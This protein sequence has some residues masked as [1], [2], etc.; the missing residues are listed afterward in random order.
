MKI[1]DETLEQLLHSTLL[2]PPAGFAEQLMRHVQQ[3]PP[4]AT[5]KT[6]LAWLQWAA[7]AGGALLGLEKL[8][9]FMFGI[10]AVSA[11]G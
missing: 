1:T 3:L 9:A 7:L 6:P 8:A 2:E 10:W 5:E 4:P 11:A